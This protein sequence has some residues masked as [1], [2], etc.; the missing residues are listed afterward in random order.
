MNIL[1]FGGTTEGRELAA[2]LAGA[3]HRVTVSVATELGAEELARVEGISVLTGRMDAAAM[4]ERLTG[5]GADLCIDAT[6]PY[7]VEV[8]REIE[9]ACREAGVRRLRLVR[10]AGVESENA[11]GPGGTV[12]CREAVVR[13]DKPE[14]QLETAPDAIVQSTGRSSVHEEKAAG[15]IFREPIV[16]VPDAGAAAFYLAGTEGNI[17]L[18]TGAKEVGAFSGLGAERVYARVLPSSESIGKCRAAGIPPR[19]II[20]MFGPFSEQMNEVMLR[21][22]GIR[23]L[24]TKDGGRA[25]GYGEKLSAARRCGVRVIVISRPEEEG[26]TMEEILRKVAE[27]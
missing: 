23:W 11:P 3:G 15:P 16:Y 5:L 24:V 8:T 2:A 22:F 26:Y 1:I 7:A 9:A 4:A 17:L 27:T 13:E 18:T 19:H 12:S 10:P 20:A 21:D 25:G 6:H 14:E